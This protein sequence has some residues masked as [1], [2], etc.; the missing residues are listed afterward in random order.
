M[1]SS[2]A[3]HLLG[4]AVPLPLGARA[5]VVVAYLTSVL[6]TGSLDQYDFGLFASLGPR[7]SDASVCR[8]EPRKLD[9][10]VLW[11]VRA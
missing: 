6:A 2:A 1:L 4:L 7:P 10:L 11:I 3:I 8:V 9:K 5:P